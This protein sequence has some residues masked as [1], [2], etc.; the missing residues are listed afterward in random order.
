MD[1]SINTQPLLQSDS[2][3]DFDGNLS[4]DTPSTYMVDEPVVTTKDTKPLFK[5]RDP[6]DRYVCKLSATPFFS[7]KE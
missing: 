5:G 7:K 4:D 6:Q 3:S 2:D 1:N